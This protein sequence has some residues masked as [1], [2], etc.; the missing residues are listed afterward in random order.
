M[1]HAGGDYQA[2][3]D[4]SPP[5]RLAPPESIL[6]LADGEKAEVRSSL[7]EI[8][9]WLSERAEVLSVID[10]VRAYGARPA[11]PDE[12]RPDLIVVLGGDGSVLA[13][14]QRHAAEPVPV[15]GVNFGHVG[16]LAP[17][18]AHRWREDLGEV[19]AGRAQ[20]E[21]RMM[22]EAHVGR[23]GGSGAVAVALNDV[24]LGRGASQSLVTLR[25]HVGG[26]LVGDYRAD[27]VV[28]AT[29]SGSTAYSLAAGGPILAPDMNGIVVTPIAAHALANR[30][31]VLSPDSRVE[32]TVLRAAGEATFAVD[33]RLAEP[34]HEGDV[35]TLQRHPKVYPLLA[36]SGMDPWRRLRERLGWRGTFLTEE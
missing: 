8:T 24:V 28:L 1:S 13:V 16:F 31:L 11:S 27:G 25:L 2:G 19:L 4:G 22:L 3:P 26:E 15:V 18:E 6:V 34:V 5:A 20:V 36:P 23:G 9:S 33:G 14:A 12:P 30:P 32:V 35:I 17:V 10:D 7:D 21:P 29:P